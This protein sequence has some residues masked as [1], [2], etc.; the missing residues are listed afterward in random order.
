MCFVIKKMWINTMLLL[1]IL[2]ACLFVCIYEPPC[3][4]CAKVVGDM[5]LPFEF[6]FVDAGKKC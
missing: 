6:D 5:G 4:M 1:L 2:F 3:L